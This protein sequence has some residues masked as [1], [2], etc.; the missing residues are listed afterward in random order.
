MAN[1]SERQWSSPYEKRVE[2]VANVM[3]EHAALSPEAAHELAVH[4]LEALG[5]IPEKVR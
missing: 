2:L 3:A 4:V 5:S 1:S